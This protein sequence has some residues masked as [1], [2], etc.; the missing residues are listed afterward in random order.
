M[1]A[2]ERRNARGTTE[3]NSYCKAT[4]RVPPYAAPRNGGRRIKEMTS[5]FQP[6]V[7]LLRS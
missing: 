3:L 4:V 2:L 6:V 5:A 1:T 7:P